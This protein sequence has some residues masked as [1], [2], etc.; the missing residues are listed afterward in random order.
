MKN[1]ENW[2]RRFVIASGIVAAGLA[3]TLPAMADSPVSMAPPVDGYQQVVTDST[4]DGGSDTVFLWSDVPSGQEVTVTRAV[5]DRGG[6]QLYDDVGETIIVPFSNNNLYVMKFGVS[7]NGHMYFVDDNGTPILFVPRNGYLENATVNGARWYP[8]TQ[9]FQPAEPVYLGV[10]P[11]WHS[12]V[13]MGWYP[14]M[15]YTGGYWCHDPYLS[16]GI[17]E[18]SFGLDIVIGDNHFHSWTPYHDYYYYNPAPY[19]VGW[20]NRDRYSWAEQPHQDRQFWGGGNNW[21]RA[22]R[23]IG[24]TSRWETSRVGRSNGSY[25][26]DQSQSTRTWSNSGNQGWGS[27]GHQYGSGRP[28]DTHTW[29]DTT[30]TGSNGWNGSRSGTPVFRGGTSTWQNGG[31][32]GSTW[33]GGG[34]QYNGGTSTWQNGGGSGSTWRGGGRQ[35]NS[36]TSWQ[37]RSSGGSF[38]TGNGGSMWRGG[39][40]QSSG[41]SSWQS[42][43]SGGSFRSSGG[44]RSSGGFSG[45]RNSGNNSGGRGNSRGSSG[46]GG[47][48][49]R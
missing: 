20:Y 47:R 19:R 26:G 2:R 8:F 1:S 40:R 29:R 27:S 39:D 16:G 46:G 11:S 42:R 30:S 35:F 43:P 15:Y 5:F 12:Y 6:Y 9:D 33:R 24:P 28:S 13:T 3:F 37:G 31:G 49:T 41:G 38:S 18:P 21:S 17:F 34:R 32:G 22:S 14:D 44:G 23:P 4:A 10:A 48:W 45:G 25:R 7:D 36:G